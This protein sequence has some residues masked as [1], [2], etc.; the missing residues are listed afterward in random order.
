[1]IWVERDGQKA[2]VIGN[3]GQQLK[4]IGSAARRKMEQLFERKIYLRLWVKVREGWVD[5]ETMLKKFG[6]T[7]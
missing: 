2:I 5:D 1:V 7:D 3:G 6:Y 4:A